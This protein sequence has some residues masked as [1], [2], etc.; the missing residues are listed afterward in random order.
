MNWGKFFMWTGL[1]GTTTGGIIYFSR[2]KRTSAELETYAKLNIF[3]LNFKGLIIQVDV[4]L[5]N[6]TPTKFT[7]KFPFVKLIYKGVTVGSSQVVNKDIPIPEYG[8]AVA[9]KIMI[10]IQLREEVPLVAGLIT[11]LLAGESVKLSVTKI[12]T[13]DLGL[14]KIPYEKTE[15][16]I[17]KK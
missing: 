3:K 9:E 6:P 2:L 8:E 12:T 16:V 1:I 17:L 7:I 14:T 10:P 15:E 13:I 4:Q 5:K 11:S